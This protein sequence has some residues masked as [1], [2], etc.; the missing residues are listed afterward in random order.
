MAVAPM[1]PPSPLS[2]ADRVR[3]AWQRRHETDYIFNFATFLGWTILTC[4]IYA[5]YGFYQLMRRSREHNLRRIEL[6]DGATEFA[7]DRCSERGIAEELRPAFE[8]ISAQ[9]TTLRQLTTEFRDPALWLVIAVIATLLTGFGGTITFIVGFILLDGDLVRHDYAEGAVEAELSAIY[10]RLGVT[11][12]PPDPT[13]LKQRHN[14]V[15]RIIAT[16]VTCGIYELWWIYNVMTDTNRHF[17]HN[18]PWEDE[19]ARGVQ[20][21]IAS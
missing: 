8:R 3:I 10:E 19:L 4:G 13:R 17:Q 14:Y 15:G 6:L 20:S 16:L 21:L 5:Y 12:T 11:I 2:P 9:M 18:W 7:W 1:A